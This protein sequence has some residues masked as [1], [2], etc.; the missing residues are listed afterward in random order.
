MTLTLEF[1]FED[2]A[3]LYHNGAPA[4][5]LRGEA[6]TGRFDLAQKQEEAL[7]PEL[8]LA[9]ETFDAGSLLWCATGGEALM[10]ARLHQ[11]AGH[12]AVIFV[13]TYAEHPFEAHVVLTSWDLREN[14]KPLDSSPVMVE[15]LTHGYEGESSEALRVSLKRRLSSC[16][17]VEVLGE[18]TVDDHGGHFHITFVS[19]MAGDRIE[20]VLTEVAEDFEGPLGYNIISEV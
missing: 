9:Q 12:E 2:A 5:M 13:D 19:K 18:G 1:A 7:L 17:G 4:A 14:E 10:L 20:E 11:A 16:E 8:L 15:V 6:Q 3:M